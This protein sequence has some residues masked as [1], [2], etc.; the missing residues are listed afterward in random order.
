M[1]ANLR[2]IPE[3]ATKRG[4]KKTSSKN[5]THSTDVTVVHGELLADS[6][7]KCPFIEYNTAGL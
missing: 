6:M 2:Y 5:F 1:D 7:T 3:D 4:K